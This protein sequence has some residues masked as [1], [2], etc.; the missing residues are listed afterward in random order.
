MFLI[1]NILKFKLHANLA[2]YMKQVFAGF[3]KKYILF[4]Y[5][6]YMINSRTMLKTKKTM[7]IAHCN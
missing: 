7:D 6:F 3:K 5:C 1:A 2:Y 4:S